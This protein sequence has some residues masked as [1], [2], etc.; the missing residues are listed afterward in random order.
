MACKQEFTE[1]ICVLVNLLSFVSWCILYSPLPSSSVFFAGS[2][3][4][5]SL[6]DATAQCAHLQDSNASLRRTQEAMHAS[7]EA[8]TSGQQTIEMVDVPSTASGGTTAAGASAGAAGSGIG[9][10]LGRLRDEGDA[11]RRECGELRRRAEA[12]EQR[13]AAVTKD[14]ARH[15]AACADANAQLS[16][17]RSQLASLQREFDDQELSLGRL[18]QRLEQQ[19]GAALVSS[20]SQRHGSDR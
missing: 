16:A 9:A 8:F 18:E 20:V 11:A 13:V 1:V 5:R 3:T 7:V 2:R 6:S 14:C 15:E 17:A 4:E 19:L 10:L 12:A